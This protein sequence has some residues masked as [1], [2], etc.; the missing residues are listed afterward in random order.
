MHVSSPEAKG[1]P[2]TEEMP[3]AAG[4]H[5][6]HTLTPTSSWRPQQGCHRE[7]WSPATPG[8]LSSLGSLL[9]HTEAVRSLAQSTF[10]GS[11][12]VRGARV[13]AQQGAWDTSPGSPQRV[14]PPREDGS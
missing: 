9:T 7:S 5:P 13:C 6:Q 8:P 3:L 10:T 14:F 2:K 11:S 12:Y 1:C 4:T